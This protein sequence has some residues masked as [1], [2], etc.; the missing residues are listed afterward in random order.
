MPEDIV[1]IAV[2]A[3]NNGKKILVVG[4]QPGNLG[5][6]YNTKD[7]RYVFWDMSSGGRFLGRN[8]PEKTGLVV[9]TQFIDHNIQSGIRRNVSND[10]TVWHKHFGTGRLK[11][12][13]REVMRLAEPL[14][15]QKSES[16]VERRP[17]FPPRLAEVAGAIKLNPPQ[18]QPTTV[19]EEEPAQVLVEEKSLIEVQ[20]QDDPESSSE[21]TKEKVKNGELSGFVTKYADFNKPMNIDE[22]D[23]LVNLAESLGIYTSQKSVSSTFYSLRAKLE[24]PTSEVV[25]GTSVETSTTRVSPRK[26][27]PN[28]D[29]TALLTNIRSQFE[30]VLLIASNINDE[31]K[32]LKE[33][34]EELIEGKRMAEAKFE[35]YKRSIVDALSKV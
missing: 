4:V 24:R 6:L 28:K 10:C 2:R 26:D 27:N 3:L 23:R 35:S 1:N 33:E 5:E 12:F 14:P 30:Q 29:I 25:N 19:V 18:P 7:K 21:R 11:D 15:S 8:V 34:K 22:L 9:F 31:N 20:V 32:R 17:T 16:P 13:L